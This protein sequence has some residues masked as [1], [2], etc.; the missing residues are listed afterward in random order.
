VCTAS[1]V[2]TTPCRARIRITTSSNCRTYHLGKQ[3]CEGQS[4][5]GQ[6]TDPLKAQVERIGRF[7]QWPLRQ[8][9][10]RPSACGLPST[11]RR[12]GEGRLGILY[13]HSFHT[14][15]V[16][17]LLFSVGVSHSDMVGFGQSEKPFNVLA[18]L[19]NSQ[20]T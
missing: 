15:G 11:T 10:C 18:V 7:G 5:E 17:F 20:T 4:S 3:A 2:P 9:V 19:E 13:M 8:E 1:L 6:S 14:L 16:V 12:Q